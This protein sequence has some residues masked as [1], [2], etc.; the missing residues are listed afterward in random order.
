[1]KVAV[2]GCGPAG[3]MAAHAAVL[4]GDEVTIISKKQKS[5]IHGAQYGHKAVPE[6]NDH[7]RPDAR[8]RYV[9]IGERKV[10]ASKVYGDPD[11]PCSWDHF[12]EGL[13][14]GWSLHDTY[15]RLWA[16]YS[17]L[18]RD[19]KGVTPYLYDMTIRPHYDLVISSIPAYSLCHRKDEHRFDRVH[20]SFKQGDPVEIMQSFD[21]NIIVY[22]GQPLDGWYRAS[23]IF[24]HSWREFGGVRDDADFQGVK[25]I[26]TNC[27]CYPEIRRVGRFGR[28]Q[29][30]A[31]TTDAFYYTLKTLEVYA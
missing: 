10:Y 6:L 21:E 1:M 18:V 17:R 5:H 11:A 3:L 2:L 30:G 28:W 15:E 24:G 12:E 20:V 9:K 7:R 23:R 4:N 13:H 14:K 8:I 19:T 16:R 25:P 26:G 29:K 31:L 27:D 22:S